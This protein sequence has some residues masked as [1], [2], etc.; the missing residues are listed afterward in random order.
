[1]PCVDMMVENIRE[2]F[3]NTPEELACDI[4]E[5]G[6]YLSGGGA[7][8]DGLNKKLGDTLGIAVTVS[9]TPQDDVARGLC[10]TA[11]DDRLAQNLMQTGCMNEV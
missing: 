8:L 9:A 4:L 2:A 6:I 10:M 3:E 7:L 11:S 5:R 1:M